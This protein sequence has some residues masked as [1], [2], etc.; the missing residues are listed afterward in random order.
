MSTLVPEERLEHDVDINFNILIPQSQ[1]LSRLPFIS[2]RETSWKPS[3]LPY[4]DSHVQPLGFC[5]T[6]QVDSLPDLPFDVLHEIVKH[7]SL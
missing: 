5:M 3:V 7:V 1:I 4:Q 2:L 6:A